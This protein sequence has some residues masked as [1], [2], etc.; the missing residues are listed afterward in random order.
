MDQPEQPIDPFASDINP[1]IL[2]TSPKV[3]NPFVRID[4]PEEQRT[5]K[6]MMVQ[7]DPNFGL[8]GRARA[9]SVA[10]FEVKMLLSNLSSVSES[11]SEADSSEL[12]TEFD[13]SLGKL[14]QEKQQKL[15][16]S[17]RKVST[18]L[19]HPPRPPANRRSSDVWWTD[20]K[21]NLQ[22]ETNKL[23]EEPEGKTSPSTNRRRTRSWLVAKEDME[24]ALQ[25]ESEHSLSY[26]QLPQLPSLK[27]LA[28]FIPPVTE[29]EKTPEEL[30]PI[31]QPENGTTPVEST[32]EETVEPQE[33]GDETSESEEG[34]GE[35]ELAGEDTSWWESLKETLEEEDPKPLDSSSAPDLPPVDNRHEKEVITVK[36]EKKKRLKRSES[37]GGEKR[38]VL[39][40]DNGV[41]R[42]ETKVTPESYSTAHGYG[43][44]NA[45]NG[46]MYIGQWFNG[47][48]EGK[49]IKAWEDGREYIGQWNN[50]R[51]SGYGIMTH[52][53]GDVYIGELQFG[54][55]QGHG[56]L[57]SADG[58]KYIG[59]W[60]VNERHGFGV[61]HFKNGDIYAGEW[62]H[63][64]KEGHG[65]YRFSDGKYVEGEWVDNK[66]TK[67][68]KGDGIFTPKPDK[69]EKKR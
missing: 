55:Q 3:R 33:E 13:I 41:Y 29:E 52:P 61:M 30:P 64:K 6:K 68:K 32:P 5:R 60:N 43:T 24:K 22:R 27:E 10:D 1:T 12:E 23:L 18:E 44:F 49:G 42:G 57:R 4:T 36:K 16:K 17:P 20:M 9:P 37:D 40:F 2:P 53:N 28:T 47:K 34:D 21:T 45:N 7:T 66:F 31:T 59:E 46:E 50:N 35:V 26:E 69:K 48:R 62:Q 39:R 19:P 11:E 56:M 54:F 51:R 65:L 67:K 63:N 14:E 15:K 38:G 8:I 58:D 25:Q